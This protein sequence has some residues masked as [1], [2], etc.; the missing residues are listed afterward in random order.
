MN[1]EELRKQAWDNFQMQAGQ[2]LT[3]FNF[4]IALSSVLITGI[5]ATFKIGIKIH[6]LGAIL[7]GLLVLFSFIFWKL[8]QRN[9]ILIK[10]AEAAL[11]FFEGKSLLSDDGCIPHP[12][13]RFLREEYDTNAHK[14]MRSWR[15]WRNQYSYYECFA[16]VFIVFASSGL[17]GGICSLILQYFMLPK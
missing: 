8:D 7:G 1:E 15:I 17:I 2:R 10:S 12:A 14:Q 13:K 6:F 9:R 5:A 16:F 3:T 4:Y 11:K